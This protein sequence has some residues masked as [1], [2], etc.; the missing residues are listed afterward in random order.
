MAQSPVRSRIH[1][2]AVHGVI[3]AISTAFA[4]RGDPQGRLLIDPAVRADPVAF[5]EELRAR[6]RPVIKCRAMYMTVD[7]KVAYDLLRS[8]YFVVFGLG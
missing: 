8:D 2:F 3:R 4:R 1:W 5:T 6:G 7:H